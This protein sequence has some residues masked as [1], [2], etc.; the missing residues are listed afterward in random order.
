MLSKGRLL[1]DL[2]S[3]LIAATRNIPHTEKIWRTCVCL[4]ACV[5]LHRPLRCTT[6]LYG[7]PGK[8]QPE[9]LMSASRVPPL[10]PPPD[11]P[12]SHICYLHKARRSCL[13]RISPVC[14]NVRPVNDCAAFHGPILGPLLLARRAHSHIRSG[15]SHKKT[16]VLGTPWYG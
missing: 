7:Q 15:W 10:Q 12:L 14:F 11:S 5:L 4:C 6:L 3:W 13:P 16:S 2:G 9:F 1:P 8:P